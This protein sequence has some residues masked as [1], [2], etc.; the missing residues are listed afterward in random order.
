ME[1][2]NLSDKEIKVVVIMIP[3]K[4]GRR[5]DKH[6]KN[7]KKMTENIRKCQTEVTELKR[8]K[9]KIKINELKIQ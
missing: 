7:F 4:L 6:S 8:T 1:I 2:S 5:M 3:T 9:Q